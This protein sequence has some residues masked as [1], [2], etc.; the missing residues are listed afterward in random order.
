M[1]NKLL[2][3]EKFAHHMM[4]L[5]FLLRD[6][7]QLLSGC[8]PL[9]QNKLQEQ[10]VQDV[11]NRNK[12]KFKPYGD[13]V[14]QTFSQFNENSINNQDPHSQIGKDGTPEAEYANENDSED[15]E[16][17]K[18]SVIPNFMPEILPDDEIAKGINS[19]N[20]KQREVFSVVHILDKHY[21]KYDGHD[22]EPVHIFLSGSGGAGKS[23]LVKVIYNAISKTLFYLCKDP[24]KPRVLLL[25]P[26]GISAANIG[27]TTIH[28]GLAI[29]PGTKLLGLNGK[30][31]AALR[32][33]LSEVKLL[34]IDEFSM[35]SSDL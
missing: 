8:P 3:L 13:L 4:V 14:D 11:V 17:N 27:G 16:T 24:E 32:S 9:H 34:I 12:I 2:S 18:T 23:H 20:A 25:G 7:K 31:K 29:K 35:V 22:V 33:R 21:V 15:T 28:C 6:E 5:F 30:S 10:G 26:T 19:L 1:S